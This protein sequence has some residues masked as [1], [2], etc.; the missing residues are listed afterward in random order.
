VLE[1]YEAAFGIS[2][3]ELRHSYG[4]L[5]DHGNLSSASILAVLDR[6]LREEELR[7]ER[8]PLAPRDALLVAMG[9]GLSLEL[10]VLRFHGVED[11][12][13]AS[14]PTRVGISQPTVDHV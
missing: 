4:V 5:R 9:P 2:A 3:H 10:S 8:A 11:S 1:A 14:T 7:N 13:R 12:E 6:Q